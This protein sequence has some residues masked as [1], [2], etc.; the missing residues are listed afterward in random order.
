[1]KKLWLRSGERA[2]LWF[3]TEGTEFA[4]PLIHVKQVQ[5]PGKKSFY[6][7]VLCG[8]EYAEDEASCKFCEDLNEDGR[9]VAM[10]PFPRAV[11]YVYV[12]SVM[13]LEAGK[14]ANGEQHEKLERGDVII[15]RERVNA[16]R[17]LICRNKLSE[18]IGS[19]F[20]G[21]VTDDDY[22]ESKQTL[23]GNS[24]SMFRGTGEGAAS[25]EAITWSTSQREKPAGFDEAVEAL[26]PL[27][28]TVTAEFEDT[29][30]DRKANGNGAAKT[31]E[32]AAPVATV[33][34]STED[35]DFD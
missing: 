31:E 8:K 30:K 32:T 2:T 4:V 14:G 16:V 21:D 10:G 18:Q 34:I 35:I 12:E 7:D 5:R 11:F 24:M 25:Q 9:P 15:Y 19:L 3:I 22:D 20:A 27:P 33:P 1:M 6:K 26:E 17:L 23:L 13:H 28:D 29:W